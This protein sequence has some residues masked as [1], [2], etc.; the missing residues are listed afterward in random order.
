MFLT[1]KGHVLVIGQADSTLAASFK[2]TG[3]RRI[4]HGVAF[5]TSSL[6]NNQLSLILPSQFEIDVAPKAQSLYLFQYKSL[7]FESGPDLGMERGS[8]LVAQNV[9]TEPIQNPFQ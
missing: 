5:V 1:A 3:R 9:G 6:I 2:A 8:M 4:P 7:S